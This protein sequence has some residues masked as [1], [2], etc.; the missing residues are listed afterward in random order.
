VLAEGLM[1]ALMSSAPSVLYWWTCRAPFWQLL[2]SVAGPAI[3]TSLAPTLAVTRTAPLQ[4]W[5][6]LL[7]P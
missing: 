5:F 6:A 3:S 1:S 4:M 2:L 7:E